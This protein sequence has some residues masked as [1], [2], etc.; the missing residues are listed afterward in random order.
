MLGGLGMRL[1]PLTENVPKPL[2]KVGGKPILETIVERF[3]EQGFN[4]FVF[5]VNYLGHQIQ[6]YFGDGRK[7]GINIQYVEESKQLGTAGALSLLQ[8][9]HISDSFIVM[10]GDLLT[11]VDFSAFL[12]MHDKQKNS[13]TVGVR[14]YSQQVPY[15]VVEVEAEKV[16][17]I[18]EKPVYRYFVNAGIYALSPEVL[19]QIVFNEYLDMPNLIDAL[20]A[21]KEIVGAFPVTEYWKDIGHL[22]DLEEA[23]V[24]YE[25]H[26]TPVSTH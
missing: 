15:G 19:N 13:V 3:S 25:I 8:Q 16:S 7:W 26:F 11:K 2:I 14:E 20:M 4:Q 17:Q 24:D 5:C 22:P 21:K 6:D 9:E 10:N 23:Q 1:R 18:V 12:D